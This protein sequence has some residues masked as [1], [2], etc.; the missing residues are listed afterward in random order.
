MI[1]GP[2]G[3]KFLA[4]REAKEDESESDFYDQGGSGNE[5]FGDLSGD[6]AYDDVEGESEDK[7]ERGDSGMEGLETI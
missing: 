5:E 2:K 6:D 7:Y 1:E 3:A 4:H